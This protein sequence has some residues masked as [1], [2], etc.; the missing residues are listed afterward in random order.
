MLRLKENKG[1]TLIAQKIT[2]IVMLILVGVTINVALN[3]GVFQKAEQAKTQTQKETDQEELQLAVVAALNDDLEIPDAS[4]IKNNLSEGWSVA[5]PE[6]GVYTCISPKL[7]E[8]TVN[9]T[10][11]KITYEGISDGKTEEPKFYGVA[12]SG[13]TDHYLNMYFFKDGIVLLCDEDGYC[14]EIGTY[15]KNENQLELVTFETTGTLSEDLNTIVLEGIGEFTRN[16]NDIIDCNKDEAPSFIYLDNI[17]SNFNPGK[18]IL[19]N[20]AF[21]EKGEYKTTITITNGNYTLADWII[22]LTFTGV[23]SSKEYIEGEDYSYDTSTGEI[24]MFNLTEPVLMD[25]EISRKKF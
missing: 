16:E 20:T 23:V 9:E 14:E 6:N 3:G 4:A 18:I 1:I 25:M 8:F 13:Y 19:S 2:I 22:E 5:G 12:Y 17:N 21:Q 7:N 24:V 11:K 10:D 15:I